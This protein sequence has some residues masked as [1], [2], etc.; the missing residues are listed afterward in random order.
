[1]K[2]EMPTKW[3]FARPDLTA[4]AI[5]VVAGALFFWVA[6]R[7]V[8]SM[9]ERH[10]A[11]E[12]QLKEQRTKAAKTAAQAEELKKTLSDV[13]A[14]LREN[15]VQLE[16]ASAVNN[17]IKR[18]TQLATKQGLKVDEIQPA[19]PKYSRDYGS[20]EITLTGKGG[21]RTWAGFLHELA[22]SS[23][24]TAI[25]SFQLSEQTQSGATAS[26]AEFHVNL[27]WYVTPQQALAKN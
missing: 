1:M 6:V 20:V 8:L 9:N 16:P 14:A 12:M 10:V 23:P 2:V 11:G 24:D 22:K 25:E 17:K 15:P 19:A 7:P 13:K 5:A 27:V 3:K 21:Y 18:L 26:S 4:L